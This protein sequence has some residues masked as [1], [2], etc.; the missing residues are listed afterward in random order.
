MGLRKSLK[1]AMIVE[2][3][4]MKMNLLGIFKVIIMC[5]G[6]VFLIIIECIKKISK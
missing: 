6:V 3:S 2:L 1:S 5:V 4:T